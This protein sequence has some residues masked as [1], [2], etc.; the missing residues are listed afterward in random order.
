MN[1]ESNI[2]NIVEETE[3]KEEKEPRINKNPRQLI[4]SAR[5]GR[6]QL[7]PCGSKMK[8]KHCCLIKQRES[9]KKQREIRRAL[10]DIEKK[11]QEKKRTEKIIQD[12]IEKSEGAERENNEGN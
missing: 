8:Y 12:G 7:C 4:G 1:S 2:A 3:K 10:D 5:I 11:S 9:I 6:N